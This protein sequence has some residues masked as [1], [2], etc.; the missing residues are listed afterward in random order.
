MNIYENMLFVFFSC[1]CG[2]IYVNVKDTRVFIKF[3][4]F[5]IMKK[6]KQLE[7][8]VVC[9]SYKVSCHLSVIKKFSLQK[10]CLIRHL[11]N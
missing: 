10:F 9:L 7:Q 3:V 2:L 4:K 8:T 1:Y 5:V 6:K 11:K